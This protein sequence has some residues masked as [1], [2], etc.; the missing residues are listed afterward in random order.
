MNP[1][2]NSKGVSYLLWLGYIFGIAGV[3]R[4]YNKR[5]ISG[6][7]WFCTW[8]LLGMGTFIDLFLI[9]GMVDE[10]NQQVREKLGMS[11]NGVVNLNAASIPTV[12]TT[13]SK[14]FVPTL[15]SQDQ[16][17]IKLAQAAQRHEGQ[18]TVTRAVIET[19]ANFE[20]VEKAF[21]EM[22][23][24]GYVQVDN[25]PETGVVIYRFQEL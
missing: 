14:S 25:H 17:M 11:P 19:G 6:V 15:L 8:G 3:H 16:L 2:L 5:Y 24:K 1:P 18:L 21:L 22:L 23:R 9:P 13:V 10:H 4:I 7:L 12:V 20:Q